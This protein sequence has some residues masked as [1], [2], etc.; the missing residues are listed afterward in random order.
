MDT[1]STSFDLLFNQFH[2]VTGK[3]LWIL[4]ENPP[5]NY[6]PATDQ[7]EIISNRFD[8]VQK[9]RLQGYKANFQDFTFENLIKHSYQFVF[10]R[11]SKEK[12]VSHFVINS[13]QVLLEDTGYLVISGAKQEGIKGYIER[14][15]KRYSKIETFKADKQHWAAQFSAGAG[16]LPVLDDKDYQAIRV[17]HEDNNGCI[18]SKPGVFG[19]E[20]L[21][22]GSQLLIAQLPSLFKDK[23][24]PQNVL[25][26]GCGY[27]L[28]S[29]HCSVL[30]NAS[31]TACDNNAAAIT[32]CKKNFEKNQV[33]G[34]VIATDCTLGIAGYFD[35][36]VCNPPFHSGFTVETDLI[37]RFLVSASARLAADGIAVF[38]ANLHIPLE[39]KAKLLFKSVTTLHHNKHFKIVVLHH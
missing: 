22:Q 6:P 27:G 39:R 8:I 5:L 24:A 9:M 29:L 36:I 33:E 32:V 23:L 7:I 37:Q 13:A 25:D 35:L 12:A 4:D 11:I 15:S 1:N 2:Q 26:I 19:W 18:Y 34:Q 30:F 28:L 14:S 10:Y 21:D 17:I 16:N 3:A 20:K 38:V 31:I